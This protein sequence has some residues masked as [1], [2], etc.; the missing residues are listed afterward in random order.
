MALATTFGASHNSSTNGSTYAT[1]AFS[2][3]VGDVLVFGATCTDSLTSV[4]D[5]TLSNGAATWTK[6]DEKLPNGAGIYSSV[7]FTGIV[8]STIT[9][10]TATLDVTGDDATGAG[11]AIYVITGGGSFR[12]FKYG[13]GLASS[14]PTFSGLAALLTDSVYVAFVWNTTNPAGLTPPTSWTEDLDV[15]HLVPILGTQSCHRDGGETATSIAYGAT[16]ASAWVGYFVEIAVSNVGAASG[17]G[18][19]TATSE[20]IKASVGASSGVGTASGV[21]DT[22][23]EGSAVGTASGTGGASGIGAS[24][25]AAVAAASGLGTAAGI[26][27]VIAAAALA[28]FEGLRRNVGRMV[29]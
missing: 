28:S 19:A 6:H 24:I 7:L 23:A 13:S 5:P 11:A 10:G 18:V 1:G 20:A 16:S 25:S 2:A 29:R 17:A 26:S 9:N 12:Q 22:S 21:G 4:P 27:D 14:T 3:A 8:T 15:G